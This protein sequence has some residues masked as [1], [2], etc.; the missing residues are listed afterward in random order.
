MLLACVACC[1]VLFAGRSKSRSTYR[2]G[3]A[4]DGRLVALD[5]DFLSDGGFS[6]DYSPDVVQCVTVLMDSVYDIPNVTCHVRTRTI[7][8][9]TTAGSLHE[10]AVSERVACA[11]TSVRAGASVPTAQLRTTLATA[12]ALR[13]RCA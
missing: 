6:E 3:F 11:R 12:L 2:A 4:P 10:R 9:D 13:A 7:A 1:R 8:H 5:L